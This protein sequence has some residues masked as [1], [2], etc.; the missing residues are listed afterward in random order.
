MY[1]IAFLAAWLLGNL[2]I[3][4]NI[5]KID[6]NKFSDLLFLCFLG[7][8]IGGRIGYSFFYNLSSTIENPLTIFF[9]G[10]AA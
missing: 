8:L 2:Y 5:I 6:N 4:K 10:M 1:L 3:K 9:Y 7:I